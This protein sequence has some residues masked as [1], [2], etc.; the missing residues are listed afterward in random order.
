MKPKRVEFAAFVFLLGAF[1]AA[2]AHAQ[3]LV[4]TSASGWS[5][6]APRPESAPGVAVS[7]RADGYALKI[8]GLGVP[9]V[10]GG[11]RT[12]I[13]GLQG[14][15]Y[16][17]FRARAL[18]LDIVSVRESVTIILRW[19]GS[20]GDEVMPDYVWDF[21]RQA[22]GTILFDRVIQTPSGT[23]AADVEL[24]LQW[25]P[26]GQVAFDELSFTAVAP[27]PPRWVRVAAIYYR[28]SGTTS[29]SESVQQAARYAEQVAINYGPDIM[30][31]GEQLNVIGAPGSLDSKAEAVP[32]P[33]TNVMAEVARAHRVNI[34]FGML[35]RIDN[36]LYNTAVLL[37]RNGNITG[38]YH[39]VQ[40]PL[41]EASAGLAP[42]NS[43][44]VFDTDFGRVA[45]LICHDISFPE[46]AREAALQGAEL[47]LVPFW[48]GRAALVRARAV[49]HGIYLAVSGYDYPSE[50][51]SPLGTVL[52][53]VS[54]GGGPEVA[55]ADIDLSQ[56]FREDWGGDWRDISNKERRTE[57]YRYSNAASDTTPPT[58]AI[59]SPTD[60]S[61]VSGTVTVA[62]SASDDVGLAGVQFFVDGVML[63]AEDTTSPY[64]VSWDTTT[65]ANGSHTLMAVARDAAGNTAPS[66]GVMVTV[67]NAASDTT[68]PTVAISSPTGGSTVSGTVT[69]AASA[70]DDVGLAGVQFFVDGVM[71]GAEDMTSPYSVPWDTTTVANGSHALT[72]V[73]R[74]AAGNTATSSEVAVTVSNGAGG[75]E[76][77][78]WTALVN[79]TAMGSTL[80]KT[81]GCDGCEDAG[82]VSSQSIASGDGYVELTA[83][84][85]TTQ[86]VVGLSYG[87][88]NTTSADID[89]AI[90]F[91]P[92]GTADVREN[93]VY[94][95]A[96]TTYVPGDIFRVA[97]QSGVVRYSKNGTVFYTSAIVPSFPLLVDTCIYS[98]NGTI[99]NAVILPR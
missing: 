77:V 29:G 95:N 61:T 84:E 49:E 89:F 22:D 28:P 38:K 67:S 8:Y 6:F 24:V 92:G 86:R 88:T 42:G 68:P 21:R 62:A 91:W 80:Q 71:L 11:W 69:V 47:L 50:V 94:R 27:S 56:R 15:G 3:E 41:Q 52:A 55:V 43:V 53:S 19:R 32:G 81:S 31:L 51:V 63:G 17:R 37:D 93:G 20:F 23:S 18:P 10:Y 36:L 66:S 74:D 70:S 83:S 44:P 87:N 39:K 34:V 4:P 98:R 57:P 97:V 65:V 76:S 7:E 12:R 9:N 33:S 96:E 82:A 79:T 14:G 64:S 73:A 26:N 13:N 59:S 78:I 85:I 46:P 60:G 30:V 16:Y 2:S 35:E 1:L 25:S 90:Q 48:G 40:L 99:S 54:I 5:A 72:A 75:V 58:V 45:L